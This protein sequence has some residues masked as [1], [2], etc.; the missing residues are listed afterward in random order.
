MKDTLPRRGVDARCGSQ[1]S[2]FSGVFL[3]LDLFNTN[4]L[5]LHQPLCENG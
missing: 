5:D 1:T 3:S 2:T 4:L